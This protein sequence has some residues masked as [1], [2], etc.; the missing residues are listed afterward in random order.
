M[1]G[2]GEEGSTRR[3]NLRDWDFWLR[4]IGVFIVLRKREIGGLRHRVFV[5]RRC[6]NRVRTYDGGWFVDDAKHLL[7]TM[8]L[9]L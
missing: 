1:R 3:V 4:E 7:S 2:G 9:R 6:F 5:G 8:L